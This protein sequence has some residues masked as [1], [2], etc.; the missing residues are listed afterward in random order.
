MV[1]VDGRD[2]LC[3]LAETTSRVTCLDDRL[4]QVLGRFLLDPSSIEDVARSWQKEP[5]SR[6]E[7]MVLMRA[8]HL[9]PPIAPGTRWSRTLGTCGRPRSGRRKTRNRIPPP[10]IHPGERFAPR[11]FTVAPTLWS[12]AAV[13]PPLASHPQV[14]HRWVIPV[15]RTACAGRRPVRRQPHDFGQSGFRSAVDK[16]HT[17]KRVEMSERSGCVMGLPVAATPSRE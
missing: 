15:S 6:G 3:V 4:G 7:G 10:E 2:N 5:N 11:P 16:L 17:G 14:G 8:G 1:A 12:A 9:L 13:A